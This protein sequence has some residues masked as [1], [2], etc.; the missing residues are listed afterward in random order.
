M[1]TIWRDAGL[2]LHE[3]G[4]LENV[5]GI[6]V[7]GRAA[8]TTAAASVGVIDSVAAWCSYALDPLG[9]VEALLNAAVE[10]IAHSLL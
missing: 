10:R 3:Q 7:K 8:A 4:T 9:D 6:T 2:W 1:L 5:L